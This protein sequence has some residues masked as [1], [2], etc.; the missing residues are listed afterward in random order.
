MNET[1]DGCQRRPP[2]VFPWETELKQL[3]ARVDP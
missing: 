1:A 3:F 2:R